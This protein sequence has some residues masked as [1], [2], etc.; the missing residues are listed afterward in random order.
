MGAY[1]ALCGFMSLLSKCPSE[2]TTIPA[3]LER[4]LIEALACQFSGLKPFTGDDS[5]TDTTHQ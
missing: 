4:S 5:E 1:Q 2:M 3:C